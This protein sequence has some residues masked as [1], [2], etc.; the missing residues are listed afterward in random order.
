M[1]RRVN[2][3]LLDSWIEQNGPDGVSRLAVESKVSADTI[4]RSR[5][6]GMAPKKLSTCL[7]ISGVLGV[8]V[9]E[10][11]PQENTRDKAS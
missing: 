11:F 8:N 9:D 2:R 7:L 1:D 3:P 10:L 6:S 4:K 5:A